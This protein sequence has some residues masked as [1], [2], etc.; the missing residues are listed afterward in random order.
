MVQSWEPETQKLTIHPDE[1]TISA[2]AEK[3][4]AL[5]HPSTHHLR[6]AF[7]IPG[8]LHPEKS[9]AQIDAQHA[10]DTFKVNTLGPLLLLKHFSPFLPRKK[11]DLIPV[12]ESDT[13]TENKS[14]ANDDD[15]LPPHAVWSSMAA[16]VGSTTHNRMGGWYSYRA[17][18]AAV[19]SL[20]RTFDLYLQQNTTQERPAMAIA[21]HPGT[22]K[23]ELSREFWD[24][25]PEGQLFTPE[26]AAEKLVHVVRSVGLDG[27]GR[28]W[29]WK[30]EEVL[31]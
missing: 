3:A 25:V 13:E 21:L 14:E 11:A 27:R 1:A 8:I 28:C 19:T 7:A 20:M 9:P 30:G 15:G 24:G 16:R 2:A 5:F 17:S 26:F 18:K 29:D 31:P 6:L 12:P 10:L 4:K 22:V 23:T